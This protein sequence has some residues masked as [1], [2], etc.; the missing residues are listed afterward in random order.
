MRDFAPVDTDTYPVAKAALKSN[1]YIFFNI[2]LNRIFLFVVHDRPVIGF[3]YYYNPKQDR[4]ILIS[5]ASD[6]VK[7]WTA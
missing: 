4:N 7:T 3:Y 6:S 5:V 1:I 2:S